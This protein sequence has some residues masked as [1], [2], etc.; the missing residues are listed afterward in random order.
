M[1]IS[2]KGQIKIKLLWLSLQRKNKIKNG[3]KNEYF[4]SQNSLIFFDENKI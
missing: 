1:K 3:S 4:I 2:L